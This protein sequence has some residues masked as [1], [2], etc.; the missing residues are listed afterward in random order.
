M[1]MGVPTQRVDGTSIHRLHGLH[2]FLVG[3]SGPANL[4]NPRN[5]WM[6]PAEPPSRR[7]PPATG[8]RFG[9]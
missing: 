9:G 7:S 1:R 6:N 5:L 8:D 2:R 3:L 4:C